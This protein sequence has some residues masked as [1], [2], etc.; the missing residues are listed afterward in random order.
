MLYQRNQTWSAHLNLLANNF[1]SSLVNNI[2]INKAYNGFKKLYS[3]PKKLYQFMTNLF[4][5]TNI[6]THGWVQY[7][8]EKNLTTRCLRN[9]STGVTERYTE[10]HTDKTWKNKFIENCTYRWNKHNFVSMCFFSFKIKQQDL[11]V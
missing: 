6:P 9:W 7:H 10:V 11:I 1:F 3:W 8:V 4:S 5:L 2:V